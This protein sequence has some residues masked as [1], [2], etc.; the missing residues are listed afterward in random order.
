MKKSAINKITAVII[1]LTANIFFTNVYAQLNS[2]PPSFVNSDGNGDFYIC[3]DGGCYEI[4]KVLGEND[5]YSWLC[6]V[7][8]TKSRT[9][10]IGHSDNVIGGGWKDSSGNDDILLC[11]INKTTGTLIWKSVLHTGFDERMYS[12]AIEGGYIYIA[13]YRKNENG[14]KDALIAKYDSSGTEIWVTQWSSA[15]YQ[16]TEEFLSGIC[17]SGSKLFAAGEYS[18]EEGGAV[19][20][21]LVLIVDKEDGTVLSSSDF[22]EQDV[23]TGIT[24]IENYPFGN[25]ETGDDDS[26]RAVISGFRGYEGYLNYWTALLSGEKLETIDW[27][28]EFD[29]RGNLNDVSTCLCVDPVDGN[30]TVSGYSRDSGNTDYDYMTVRYD[31]NGEFSWNDTAYY[32]NGSGTNSNDMATIIKR[33]AGTNNVLVTGY[34]SNSVDDFAAVTYSGGSSPAPVKAPAS[35]KEKVK[36]P[37]TGKNKKTVNYPNPFNSSTTISYNISIPGNVTITLF[38]LLGREVC[39]YKEGFKGIGE[40]KIKID[41][42]FLNSGVYFYEVKVDGR[43]QAFNRLTLLK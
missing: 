1:L 10:V 41:L 13:G 6:T 14:Y 40:S 42:D 2:P 22:Y 43:R 15:V 24:C 4:G 3:N 36:S 8:D 20:C 37:E 23:V 12:M 32:F 28:R 34:S 5:S 7:T 29:G 39:R 30:I 16:D 31:E 17:I 11:K 18:T 33:V 9:V 26:Y 27:Q 19:N 25:T 35:G 21:G 38:N